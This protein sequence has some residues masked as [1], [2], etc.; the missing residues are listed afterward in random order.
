MLRPANAASD[1]IYCITECAVA[2]VL[3]REEKRN[4]KK[5]EKRK[6]TSVE[7]VGRRGGPEPGQLKSSSWHY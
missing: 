5:K 4:E 6:K 7:M 3:K 1:V 2:H